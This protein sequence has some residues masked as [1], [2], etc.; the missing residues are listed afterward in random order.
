MQNL[1]KKVSFPVEKNL[2]K[3]YFFSGIVF[4]STSLLQDRDMHITQ[5]PERFSGR[6]IFLERLSNKP[7]ANILMRRELFLQAESGREYSLFITANS[8]YQLFING[9]LIGAGPRQHQSPGT[10][11]IDVYDVALNLQPGKNVIAVQI[12]WNGNSELSDSSLC[13][14]MWCQLQSGSQTL[15][16]SDE[17]W[18]IL[19]GTPQQE[20]VLCG[21]FCNLCDLRQIPENWNIPE[22]QCDSAWEQPDLFFLPG[23]PGARMELHPL[24]PGGINP[25]TV[26]FQKVSTG[27]VEKL[28]VFS[29]FVFPDTF[30]GRTGAA[31]SYIYS[32]AS[33]TVNAVLY[34]DAPLKLFCG[35]TLLFDGDAGTGNEVALQLQKGWTRLAAFTPVVKR[36]TAVMLMAAEWPE[37]LLPLNDMLD[38]SQPG[39]CVAPLERIRFSDCTSA[40][41]VEELS[42]L[43]AQKTDIANICFIRELLQTAKLKTL[44][45]ENKEW[46]ASGDFIVWELPEVHYG[47]VN[48]EFIASEGD[49]VDVITG[50]RFSDDTLLPDGFFGG[51]HNLITCCCREGK[52]EFLYP[53]PNDCCKVFFWVRKARGS[54]S[55]RQISFEELRYDFE[56]ENEFRCSEKRFNDFWKTGV[57]SLTRSSTKLLPA[58]GNTNQS[59]FLLDS[60]LESVNI[61]AVYGDSAYITSS[62]RQFAGTQLENGALTSLSAGKD[63]DLAFFHMFFFPGWIIFNYR[64]TSNLVEMRNL[65]PR[66]DAVKHYLLSLLDNK[67]GLFDMTKIPPASPGEDDPVAT[68][69]LPVVMNALLCRFMMVSSEIYD[70]VERASEERECRRLLR[71]ISAALIENFY[72][73]ETAM[74]ADHPITPDEHEDFSLLG[75]FFPLLAGLKTQESFESF[76]KTFFDFAKAESL[77]A[78]AESPYFHWLFGELLFALGQKAWGIRYLQSYWQK[79]VDSIQGIWKEPFQ[80]G[81]CATGFTGGRALVP[82]A[83]LIREILG[84]RLAEPAHSVIY[85]DP[86]L[87]AVNSAEGVI[88]TAQG[89]IRIKWEKQADGGLEI[90]IFSTHP[91]KVLPEFSKELLKQSSF[92]LG[93]NVTL[94]RSAVQ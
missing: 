93:E 12:F 54:L 2:L 51:V 40:V 81:L 10:S 92:R 72:D 47:F 64:F 31:V 85:F 36:D 88:P 24:A 1:A 21:H 17:S 41:R 90:D 20:P 65:I 61:A 89:R 32:E 49:I 13:P 5:F 16:N 14:G 39:W 42:G 59:S 73:T 80:R 78:E 44:P 19:A 77:T 52:N 29:T 75:N 57:A 8:F 62:L 23:A 28:P 83:F 55:L 63:Y 84:V 91:V 68:C 30:R 4:L 66:L 27:T 53:I 56:R 50:S 9:S 25:E 86:G 11:Y 69:R 79:R 34:A 46:L 48:I 15:L 60:F 67:T 43:A 33:L 26:E 22:Y 38:S 37:D 70:L 45:D 74:F 87:N 35:N 7:S 94:V 58:A 76:V 6:W 3:E 71:K 18:Q 82:N